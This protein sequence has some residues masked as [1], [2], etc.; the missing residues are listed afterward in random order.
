MSSGDSST[1]VSLKERLSLGPKGLKERQAALA[2]QG[3]DDPGRDAHLHQYFVESALKQ[4]VNAYLALERRCQH[5]IANKGTFDLIYPLADENDRATKYA[6]MAEVRMTHKYL[7]S[8]Y[9][10]HSSQFDGHAG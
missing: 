2:S 5:E 6:E 3:D 7:L 1:C 4:S 9:N 10:I 8:E